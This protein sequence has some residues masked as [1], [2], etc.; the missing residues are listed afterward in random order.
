M[1][2][3][4][5]N[6]TTVATSEATLR[7]LELLVTRKLDG[8]LHGDYQGVL[9]GAGTEAGDGRLYQPGDDVRRIDWNLT[10]R[11]SAPHVRDAV[12]DRE[13]EMWLVIDGSASLDFGTARCEKRDLALATAAAFGFLT[14]RAGNRLAA[15]V[16]DGTNTSVLPPRTGRNAVMAI[17]HRLD[18]RPRAGEGNADL[19]SA[20]RQARLSARRKG[21]MIVVSDLLDG[22]PWARELRGLT[23]RH[24]VVVAHVG[25]PRERELPPV[26]LLTLVD[27]ETGRRREVQTAN[28][29]LRQRFAA[30]A[31]EQW[32]ANA[33][34]VRAAG[35]AHLPLSTDRDW[36]LD[37]VRFAALRKR[38][39]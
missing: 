1:T 4:T 33:R 18:N 35:A 38:R 24:D 36:L 7:R 14:C 6:A 16:F 30:V 21:L 32:D 39:R 13:L 23:A 9:P 12:A 15:I 34:S 26:G 20:L 25:D 29:R 5:P 11:S 27:P 28:P 8:L 37:I 17:L 10:A 22:G 2:T 3:P 31:D 19:A